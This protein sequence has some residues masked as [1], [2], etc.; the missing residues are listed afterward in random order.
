MLLQ[1]PLQAIRLLTVRTGEGT[2]PAVTHLHIN[3]FYT[4]FNSICFF[5]FSGSSASPAPYPK[6]LLLTHRP[7][8]CPPSLPPFLLPGSS[9]FLLPLLSMHMSKPSQPLKL[10]LQ[11]TQPDPPKTFWCAIQRPLFLLL[12]LTQQT[13]EIHLNID[14][15]TQHFLCPPL[16]I[17]KET[18]TFKNCVFT[19]LLLYWRRGIIQGLKAWT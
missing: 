15:T 10:C 7:S 16:R 12:R 6:H 3:R 4:I 8:A 1:V 14:T 11:S 2:L 17:K 18:K 9:T 13:A 5:L 19:L